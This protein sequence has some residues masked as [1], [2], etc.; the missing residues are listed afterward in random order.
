MTPAATLLRLA[1]PTIEDGTHVARYL[2]I[3]A[4][5]AFSAMLGRRAQ[6]IVAEAYTEAGHDLA[7]E[8]VTLAERDRR[9]VASP[10][11][12]R[13]GSERC[14]WLQSRRSPEGCSGS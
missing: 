9:V 2:D 10:S 7:Y 12:E 3:A 6:S 5:G 8:H 14:G 11:S 1:R 4:Q 13:R